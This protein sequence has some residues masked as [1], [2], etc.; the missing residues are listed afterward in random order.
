M[1]YNYKEAYVCYVDTDPQ[2]AFAAGE[3]LKADCKLI[4]VCRQESGFKLTKEEQA[5]TSTTEDRVL[6]YKCEIDVQVLTA[7]SE[8]IRTAIDGKKVSLLF[9]D[10]EGVYVPDD[11]VNLG[12]VGVTLPVSPTGVMTAPMPLF[13]EEDEKYGTG[14]VQAI[15]I[16][17][18]LTKPTKDELRKTVDVITG[19]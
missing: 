13:I 16:S 17:G 5:K 2:T 6:S 3:V 14:K 4:G 12:S 18:S 10:A 9:V 11:A 7:L 8:T 15:I 1:S 19:T